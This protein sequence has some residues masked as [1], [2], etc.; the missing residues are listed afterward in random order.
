MKI[1]SNKPNKLITNH[2]L[3]KR[4]ARSVVMIILLKIFIFTI[5]L[6]SKSYQ[7]HPYSAPSTTKDTTSKCTNTNGS[8]LSDIKT[9]V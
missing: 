1:R 4:V 7:I 9:E 2:S 5:T 6:P 3:P 8:S